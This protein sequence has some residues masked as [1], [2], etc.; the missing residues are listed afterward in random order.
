[1]EDIKAGNN[2]KGNSWVY[3]KT[4]GSKIVTDEEAEKLYKKGWFDCP[5]KAK[6]SAEA[7]EKPKKAAKKAA[8]KKDGGETKEEEEKRILA[9]LEAEEAAKKQS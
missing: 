1:M 2:N 3:H 7:K 6:E 4:E 5:T 8:K 9:E